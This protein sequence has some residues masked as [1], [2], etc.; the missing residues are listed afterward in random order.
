MTYIKKL[1]KLKEKD[2]VSITTKTDYYNQVII[3]ENDIDR[4]DLEIDNNI[5]ISYFD[6]IELKII[7][8]GNK[9]F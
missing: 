6:I 9:K 1:T 5:I 4:K 2:I 8:N 7:E 3:T